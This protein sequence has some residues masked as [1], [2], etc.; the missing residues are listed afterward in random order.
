[1]VN[2]NL[3]NKGPLH[4]FQVDKI[5]AEV[6]TAKISDEKLLSQYA[7][8][9]EYY[10]SGEEDTGLPQLIGVDAPLTFQDMADHYM[11]KVREERQKG[12]LHFTE[13][14]NHALEYAARIGDSTIAFQIMDYIDAKEKDM[15]VDPK[16]LLDLWDACR[17]HAFRL[18]VAGE[19]EKAVN[20]LH[21]G[22]DLWQNQLEKLPFG[23]RLSRLIN[24]TLK[25]QVL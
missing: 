19:N 8:P 20:I 21:E 23:S 9:S 4:I 6:K 11:A 25:S 1:M 5:V 2:T 24:R 17:N 15:F 14:M 12:I 22:I 7:V 10:V 16:I 3:D 18:K 13:N